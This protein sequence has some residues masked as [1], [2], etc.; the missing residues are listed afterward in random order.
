MEDDEL[1]GPCEVNAECIFE[2]ADGTADGDG[3]KS[4]DAEEDME[5]DE[6]FEVNAEWIFKGV[7]G[8]ADGD[9]DKS[10]YAED[11]FAEELSR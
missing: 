11:I 3:G 1:S 6:P 7:D 4:K 9:G 5:E 10:E 2:V 8:A